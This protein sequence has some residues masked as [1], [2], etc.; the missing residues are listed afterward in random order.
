MTTVKVLGD[1]ALH[2]SSTHQRFGSFRRFTLSAHLQMSHTSRCASGTSS[3]HG[4]SGHSKHT[5]TPQRRCPSGRT[6]SHSN[7]RSYA[8]T[9]PRLH[10]TPPRFAEHV[11]VCG[12]QGFVPWL[13][14]N[15]RS[16]VSHE[17]HRP[18]MSYSL[19][20]RVSPTSSTCPPDFRSKTTRTERHL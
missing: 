19:V 8:G 6:V 11:V 12:A 2:K 15:Q 7:P 13:S 4:H 14:P 16:R 17:C 1:L 10:I 3:S 18:M 5:W 20:S 9:G